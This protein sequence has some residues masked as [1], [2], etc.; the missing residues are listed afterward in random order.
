MKKSSG[1]YRPLGAKIHLQRFTTALPCR[2]VSAKKSMQANRV[3][4]SRENT[5]EFKIGAYKIQ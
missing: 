1:I 3:P 5:K 2:V 4:L